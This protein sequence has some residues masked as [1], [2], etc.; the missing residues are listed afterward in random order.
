[1][2]KF[3]NL[4]IEEISFDVR[5]NIFHYLSNLKEKYDLI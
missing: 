1:M 5:N 2:N 4:F 3:Y